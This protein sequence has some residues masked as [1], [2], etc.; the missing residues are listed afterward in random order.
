MCQNEFYQSALP[1]V[2]QECRSH[3]MLVSKSINS[4]GSPEQGMVGEK[5]KEQPDRVEQNELN[6]L[7]AKLRLFRNRDFGNTGFT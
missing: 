6:L 5:P 7:F 1:W 3:I 4:T 2:S